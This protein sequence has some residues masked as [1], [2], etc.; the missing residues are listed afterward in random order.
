MKGSVAARD[1][2]PSCREKL[3]EKQRMVEFHDKTTVGTGAIP[4]DLSHAKLRRFHPELY[5]PQSLF[6][7]IPY[8]DA[9]LSARQY[10][11][12]IDEHLSYG[13]SRAALV[14]RLRPL[15]VAA[16]TD[17]QDCVVLLKFPQWLVDEYRLQ[18]GSK[19]LTIN[20]YRIG[21]R[22]APDIIEGPNTSRQYANFYPLIAQFLSDDLRI[23]F[24]RVHSIGKGEWRRVAALAQAYVSRP[25]FPV[26]DG[27]PLYSERPGQPLGS[28]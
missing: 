21:P 16:Y 6:T 4:I 13:D 19:L 12:L 25:N 7:K 28:R 5:G 26:R 23:I 20:S 15:L 10:R 11:R 9:E 14:V 8:G 17:E 3:R 18:V 27:R 24:Y 1:E 2:E 22:V